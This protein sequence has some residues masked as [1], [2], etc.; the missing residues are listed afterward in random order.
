[1]SYQIAINSPIENKLNVIIQRII[2]SGLM[3]YFARQSIFLIK[4]AQAINSH[5]A[6]ASDGEHSNGRGITMEH[7]GR[8]CDIFVLIMFGTIVVFAMEIVYFNKTKMQR[9]IMR[10]LKIPALLK[11]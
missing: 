10:L 5:A 3:D 2:E 1:M 9:S 8:L 11:Q 7:M 4:L 6:G